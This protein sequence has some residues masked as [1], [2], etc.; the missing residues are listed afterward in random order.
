MSAL[1]QINSCK[2]VSRRL[3]H[4]NEALAEAATKLSEEF[5]DNRVALELLDRLV[6]IRDEAVA[7]LK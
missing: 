1:D 4:F 2:H 3:I 5:G 6:E 7:T